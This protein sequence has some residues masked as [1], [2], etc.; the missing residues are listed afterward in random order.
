MICVQLE[1]QSR[2]ART[3]NPA[4]IKKNKCKN[5]YFNYRSHISYSRCWIEFHC[6]GLR[7][8]HS[9]KNANIPLFSFFYRPSRL[10]AHENL[11]PA[12]FIRFSRSRPPPHIHQCMHHYFQR[13]RDFGHGE[14]WSAER[15]APQIIVSKCARKAF[16]FVVA[17]FVPSLSVTFLPPPP[18]RTSVMVNVR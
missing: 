5:I 6:K 8:I 7:R 15:N 14:W 4:E 2:V 10:L 11:F 9:F 1:L 18:V 13:S 16:T 17:S 3:R 12:T